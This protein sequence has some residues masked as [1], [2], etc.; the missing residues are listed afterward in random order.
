MYQSLIWLLVLS[1]DPR[2]LSA[3]L[4]AEDR[5]RLADA[6]VDRVRRNVERGRDFLGTEVL[7]DE[8]ETVE[9]PGAQPGDSLGHQVTRSRIIGSARRLMRSVRIVQCNTHPAK[10]A[11]LPS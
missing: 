2:G 10:H 6:L 1:N 3:P 8:Q 4:D 5:K 9:L 7:V 11:V